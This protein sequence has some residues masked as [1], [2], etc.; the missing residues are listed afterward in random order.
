MTIDFHYSLDE[1]GAGVCGWRASVRYRRHNRDSFLRLA[2]RS[3][4]RCAALYGD[5][6]FKPYE[7]GDPRMIFILEN[8]APGNE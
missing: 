8:R 4:L 2:A 5:Y 1:A 6:A 3:G 7:A